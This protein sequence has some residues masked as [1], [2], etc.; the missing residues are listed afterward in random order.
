MSRCRLALLVSGG[1]TTL[2]NIID[3]IADGSLE[4]EIVT[5]ISS[6]REV[7]AVERAKRNSLSCTIIRPRDYAD[8]ALYED[9]L[10]GALM[11]STPDLI[12]L[13]G[14]MSVLGP[15]IVEAF[16][17]RIM[18]IHPSLLPAFGGR[19]HYGRYVHEKVLA[20]GA[21]VSGATVMLVDKGVDEGPI[22][23]QE[24]V[25]VLDEDTIET[26]SGRVAAVEKRLYPEAIR[27]F[28]EGRL[29]V[30]GRRVLIKDR[31]CSL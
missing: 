31:R 21:K 30:K 1:G 25:P 16:P 26:L 23:L 4:A 18:N 28:A 14:F 22:V 7:F 24:A 5:V 6:R 15:S 2:Q 10:L 19:G 29:E 20:Y 9:A 13:A 17:D 12:V 27:L 8:P 11:G 3:A